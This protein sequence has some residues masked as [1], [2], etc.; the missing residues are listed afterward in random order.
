M[1][2]VLRIIVFAVRTFGAVYRILRFQM[3][4]VCLL[5][6]NGKRVFSVRVT[7]V[8][9][10]VNHRKN[11]AVRVHQMNDIRRLFPFACFPYFTLF[12]AHGVYTVSE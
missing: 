4:S 10:S 1:Q 6:F 11:F 8:A 9:L 12:P 3:Q 7:A 5:A 2:T